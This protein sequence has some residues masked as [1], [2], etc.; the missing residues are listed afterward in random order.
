MLTGTLNDVTYTGRIK[1]YPDGS[2]EIMVC[3]KPIFRYAGWE[4]RGKE[5]RKRKAG[6]PGSAN[7]R[8]IRR[9]KAAVRDIA[10]CNEMA[11]FVTLTL[12]K[13]K[14]DR[15]DVAAVTK[16]LNAWLSNQ[17]QRKG[18]WYVLVPELHKDGAVHYHGLF[19]A[20][21]PVTDSGTLVPPGGGKPRKPRS[22]AQR[23]EWLADG[24]QIVYNLP[25]WPYGFTTAMKLHGEYDRAVSYVCKYIGKGLTEQDN[26]GKIGGRWYY[27]G[28]DLRTPHITYEDFEWRDWIDKPGA[29][30]FRVADA[31]CAFVMVREG[32]FDFFRTVKRPDQMFGW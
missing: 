9:A 21:L 11:Y 28:G 30:F 1:N 4:E 2:R 5:K 8:S 13:S 23:E 26:P 7:G 18:L 16:K 31:G 22:K 32:P 19:N 3:T 6:P 14:V 10:L 27:S 25:G 29:Y 24:G 17:V 20:A 12:D 15:H